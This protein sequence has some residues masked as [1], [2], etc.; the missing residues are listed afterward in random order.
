MQDNVKYSINSN[1]KKPEIPNL[2][3]K[4]LFFNL[5][6]DNKNIKNISKI[7]CE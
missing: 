6:F 1:I 2:D 5:K 7:F 4:E 3:I